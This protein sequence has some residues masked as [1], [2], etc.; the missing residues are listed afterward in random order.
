VSDD[1]NAADE[2]GGMGDLFA[3]MQAMQQQLTD[4]QEAIARQVVE[5][6]SGGGAVKVRCTGMLEFESVTIE[7]TAVD[8][9]DV[10]MLEDLVLAAVR[11]AVGKANDLNRD[12]LGGLTGGLANGL[13]GLGGLLP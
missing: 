11:D 1:A 9:D 10:A 4:A 2:D 13:G 6:Q 5:G 7:P 3:T 8:A 12:A